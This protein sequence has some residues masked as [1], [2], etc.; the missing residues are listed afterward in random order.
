MAKEYGVIEIME[1]NDSTGY[2]DVYFFVGINTDSNGHISILKTDDVTK[3]M[4]ITPLPFDTIGGT[5][6][7]TLVEFVRKNSFKGTSVEFKIFKIEV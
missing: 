2:V 5:R 7:K 1:Q 4:L 6:I 3:A